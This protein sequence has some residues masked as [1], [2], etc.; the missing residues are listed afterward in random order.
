M[1]ERGAGLASASAAA[2]HPSDSR[3]HILARSAASWLLVSVTAFTMTA[4][5]LL[6]GPFGRRFNH[7]VVARAGARGVLR[8]WNIKLD[9]RC[10]YPLSRTQ[11]VYISNH[12][13]SLDVA[14]IIAL[15]LPNT[16]YFM[17]GFVRRY[18]PVGIIATVMGTFFTM[19]QEYPERRRRLFRHACRVL[20]RTGESVFLTPE[21]QVTLSGEIGPFNKGAFHL[22]S[23]LQ[24]PIIPFYIQIP[25]HCDPR[26]GFVVP[27][28]GTVRVWFQEPIATH[29]WH[30]EELERH[31]DEVRAMFVR[32]DRSLRGLAG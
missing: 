11:A 24:A 8:I 19:S 20:R 17:K 29:G 3:G 18:I 22:A 16:R 5:A 28:A 14:I 13:S 15:G 12:T 25:P 23:S 27:G 9:V 21:G 4:I 6:S 32:L 26:D 30:L 7:E 1:T 10:P 31:R 2:I